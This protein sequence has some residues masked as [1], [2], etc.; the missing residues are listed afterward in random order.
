MLGSG[1]SLLYVGW[2]RV[3]GARSSSRAHVRP[4]ASFLLL[5]RAAC[6]AVRSFCSFVS[7]S[8]RVYLRAAR[9][10]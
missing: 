5:V 6:A 10:A 2:V 1:S 4:A 9:H 8:T 3:N 7:S